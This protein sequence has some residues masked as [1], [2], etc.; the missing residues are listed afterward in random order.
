MSEFEFKPGLYMYSEGKSKYYPATSNLGL[1]YLTLGE[2]IEQLRQQFRDIIENTKTNYPES[3]PYAGIQF[4]SQ[5]DRATFGPLSESVAVR[6]GFSHT[7][8][9]LSE[10]AHTRT[11]IRTQL[12]TMMTLARL[13]EEKRI[14][15]EIYSDEAKVLCEDG[16]CPCN[17]PELKPCCELPLVEEEGIKFPGFMQGTIDELYPQSTTNFNLYVE[18]DCSCRK[19]DCK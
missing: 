1:A 17:T 5:E 16:S 15:E 14:E 18:R 8:L 2:A 4:V 13:A 9:P 10:L 11:G 12:E 19:C 7:N 3:K 6:F